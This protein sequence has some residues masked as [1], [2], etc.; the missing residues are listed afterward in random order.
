MIITCRRYGG[1]GNQMFQIATT[2]AYAKRYC[3]DYY[4]PRV[5]SCPPG[6]GKEPVY[7]PKLK[8]GDYELEHIINPNRLALYS[9]NADQ[10]Y[11]E[12]PRLDV[13]DLFNMKCENVILLSG[14]FQSE[15]YFADQREKIL[16]I[17]SAPRTTTCQRVSIHVRRGDYL[18]LPGSWPAVSKEYLCSAINF[19]RE[20]NKRNFFVF[21]DDMM[22]CYENLNDR[23]FPDCNF[24]YSDS[25]YRSPESD[26]KWM[27]SCDHNIIANST[28][29]WWGAWLNPNPDK[30]VIAPK[31]W[32]GHELAHLDLKDLLPESWIKL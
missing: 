17:F 7:F 15:K 10:S 25:K 14:H 3:I 23:E 19:F 1:L 29:S 6:T 13:A 8:G 4:I 24:R 22:W 11:N 5:I 12:I 31:R 28:F 26:L 18:T 32:I 2:V 9:E 20:R 30:I 16:E 21:S 27:A